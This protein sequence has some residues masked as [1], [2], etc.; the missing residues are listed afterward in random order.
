[1]NFISKNVVKNVMSVLNE[2]HS[3]GTFM[4]LELNKDFCSNIWYMEP[5]HSTSQHILDC[6]IFVFREF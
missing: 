5:H 2:D 6:A 4:Q 1:M 3:E